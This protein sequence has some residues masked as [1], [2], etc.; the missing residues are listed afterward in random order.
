[1]QNVLQ[2]ENFKIYGTYMMCSVSFVS[3]LK[4]VIFTTAIDPSLLNI[5]WSLLRNLIAQA[6]N[7]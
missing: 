4:P 5:N 6:I 1:M 3:K 7:H 2:H